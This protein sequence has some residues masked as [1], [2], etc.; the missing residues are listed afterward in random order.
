MKIKK[1]DIVKIITGN[2]K[3][4]TGK[5][6]ATWPKANAVT[7]EGIGEFKRR[8]KPTKMNPQVGHKDIH[9]PLDVSKVALVHPTDSA[10]TTRVAFSFKKDGSKVRVARQAGDKEITS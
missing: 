1:N 9:R 2:H 5:V 10:K 6:L 7:V 3:G 4:K 8:I